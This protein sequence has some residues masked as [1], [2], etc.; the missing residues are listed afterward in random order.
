MCGWHDACLRKQRFHIADDSDGF[1]G[2]GCWT[3]AMSFDVACFI[4]HT[5]NDVLDPITI[6]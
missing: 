6:T 2:K 1:E 5:Y 3:S 4:Q